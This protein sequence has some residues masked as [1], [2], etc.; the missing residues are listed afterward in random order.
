MVAPSEAS[1]VFN[2]TPVAMTSTRSVVRADI[3]S[4]I[5]AGFLLVLHVN[6]GLRLRLETLHFD[7]DRVIADFDQRKRI[8]AAAVGDRDASFPRF[9]FAAA[10]P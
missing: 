1:S 7:R 9:G 4:H 5:D 2:S 3:K 6:S 10:L 8:V